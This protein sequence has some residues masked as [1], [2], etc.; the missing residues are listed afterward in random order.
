MNLRDAIANTARGEVPQNGHDSE[1][2]TCTNCREGNCNRCPTAITNHGRSGWSSDFECAHYHDAPFV[3]Q[4]LVEADD[5]EF[6]R[7]EPGYEGHG[8]WGRD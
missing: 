1:L 2:P 5:E 7:H 3:H 8:Y 6:Y 4:D